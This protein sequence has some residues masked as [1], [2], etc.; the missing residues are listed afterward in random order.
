MLEAFSAQNRLLPSMCIVK[1]SKEAP[2]KCP[3]LKGEYMLSCAAD[4]AVYVPS[5]FELNEY[6]KENRHKMCPFYCRVANDGQ[7]VLS[8]DTRPRVP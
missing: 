5:I 3:F 8:A 7:F 2:M 6:C 1:R 4:K